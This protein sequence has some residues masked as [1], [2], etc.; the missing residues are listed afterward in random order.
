MAYHKGREHGKYLLIEGN[1]E[2]KIVRLI[3]DEEILLFQ[4]LRLI[5]GIVKDKPYMLLKKIESGEKLTGNEGYIK[6]NSEYESIKNEEVI[7]INPVAIVIEDD[8]DYNTSSIS[9]FDD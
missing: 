6:K 8:H 4:T 3:D 5:N 2:R 9:L 7:N 1:G